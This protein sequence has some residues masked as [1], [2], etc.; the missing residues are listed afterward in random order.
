MFNTDSLRRALA[1]TTRDHRKQ[2]GLS[3]DELGR[4]LTVV[5]NELN[6]LLAHA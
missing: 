6:S 1:R 4:L 2:L 3:Q 5:A